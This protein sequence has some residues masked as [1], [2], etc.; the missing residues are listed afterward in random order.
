MAARSTESG[1]G[2]RPRTIDTGTEHLAP[3]ALLAALRAE[4]WPDGLSLPAYHSE[5]ELF[6]VNKH[7]QAQSPLM[8][9]WNAWT[10]DE[11]LEVLDEVRS[12]HTPFALPYLAEIA[13]FALPQETDRAIAANLFAA[14]GASSNRYVEVAI[15]VCDFV[16]Q[17]SID[18]L[19]VQ[20]A[21]ACRDGLVDRRQRMG[22]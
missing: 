2:S 6:L 4:K 11:K 18:D 21:Q 3:S 15:F 12:M 17:S 5:H 8:N 7:R 13:W 14:L 20:H 9:S 22:R 19:V 10:R 1:C 16:S